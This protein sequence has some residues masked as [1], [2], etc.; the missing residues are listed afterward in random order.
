MSI[1]I[2]IVGWG[3]IAREHAYHLKGAGAELT[4]IVSRRRNLDLEVPVFS[5]LNDMLP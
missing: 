1:R 3:E 2:G 4:G 5:S